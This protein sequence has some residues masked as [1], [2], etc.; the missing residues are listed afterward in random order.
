MSY[1]GLSVPLRT[2]AFTYALAYLQ[3]A[4]RFTA[5]TG[6]NLLAGQAIACITPS[7][8][9]PTASTD[10]AKYL[11]GCNEPP[12][13][14][15]E[16]RQAPGNIT[17]CSSTLIGGMYCQIFNSSS[18]PRVYFGYRSEYAD[19]LATLPDEPHTIMGGLYLW[20]EYS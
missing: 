11:T 20:I 17:D 4:P 19:G 7:H 6:H 13:D 18:P 9:D 14:D 12:K 5:S 16:I 3:K 15:N 10:P 8:F 2:Q 1:G